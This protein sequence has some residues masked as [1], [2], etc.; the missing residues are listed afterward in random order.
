MILHAEICNKFMQKA[1]N[2]FFQKYGKSCFCRSEKLF[3]DLP[4]IYQTVFP[5]KKLLL[6]SAP[7]ANSKSQTFKM[8]QP[9]LIFVFNHKF[10]VTTR[11]T[12]PFGGKLNLTNLI[13]DCE[14]WKESIKAHGHTWC[15]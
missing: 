4:N 13:I 15:A 1:Q 8:R 9:I 2:S 14:N 11:R 12:F 10:C 3:L 6:R 5:L 7:T